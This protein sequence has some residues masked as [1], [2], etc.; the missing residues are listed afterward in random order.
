MKDTQKVQVTQLVKRMIARN[1]ENKSIGNNVE[2]DVFHNSAISAADCE[3]LIPPIAI[4]SAG[5]SGLSYQRIGDR[6]KPKSL[7]V[8][9]IVCMGSDYL[10]QK[11][12][13]VRILILAQK[14]VK[15]GSAVLAGA[16]DASHLLKPNSP[17]IPSNN[18]GGFTAQL[19]YP[20]NRDL[21]RVYM[22]KTVK[23]TGLKSDTSGDSIQRQSVRWSYRFKQ[24][25]SA[26]TFDKGNGDWVNNFAPFVAI[27]YAYP[28]GTGPDSPTPTRLV[29]NVFS[30][31]TYEDA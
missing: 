18:F 23:L 29:S 5:V 14:N 20:V 16:V 15:T 10:I 19:N 17:A 31:L 21:F 3:P 13:Y 24:L 25:P 6:I 11:D 12:M 1:E 22:D 8:K 9:G 30:L 2:L 7:T 27:G 26:L 4:D 28:D